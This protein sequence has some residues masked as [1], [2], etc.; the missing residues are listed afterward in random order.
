MQGDGQQKDGDVECQAGMGTGSGV[1]QTRGHKD[2]PF[3]HSEVMTA[4]L[5]VGVASGDAAWAAAGGGVLRLLVHHHDQRHPHLQRRWGRHRGRHARRLDGQAHAG[6]WGGRRYHQLAHASQADWSDVPHCDRWLL[7]CLAAWLAVVQTIDSVLL[8]SMLQRVERRVTAK[9][10]PELPPPPP[11]GAGVLVVHGRGGGEQQVLTKRQLS[12]V[13]P[14]R[15]DQL[16]QP[17]MSPR[18]P[19]DR[20]TVSDQEEE[21]ED[22]AIAALQLRTLRAC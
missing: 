19:T 7:G 9:V 20:R 6:E 22:A 12:A 17:P 10:A 2:V 4:G 3:L 14:K 18:P 21:E 13:T 8:L 11:V 5:G 1:C 16:Q 15:M